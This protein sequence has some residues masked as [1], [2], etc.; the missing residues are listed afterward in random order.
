[1]TLAVDSA[2]LIDL[3]AASDATRAD[4]AEASIRD[5]LRQGLVVMNDVVVAEVC[6]GLGDGA[7]V[8]D[9]LREAGITLSPMSEQ[10]CVRAGEMHRKY[11][12]RQKKAPS[13]PTKS[14]NVSDFLIGA[15]AH[16]QCDGLITYDQAFFRD[17]FKGLRLITPKGIEHVA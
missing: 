2:V 12:T 11:L 1:M 13:A 14:R 9:A 16:L 3:L 17:Y 4:P 10:A 8:M 5:A 6:A 7:D 15:H